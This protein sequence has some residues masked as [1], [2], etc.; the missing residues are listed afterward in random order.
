MPLRPKQQ[1]FVD[2]YLKDLNATQAAIRAGYSK[3][4]AMQIGEQ[5]LRKL[6]IKAA[7]DE[8]IRER[9]ERVK[10]TQ[11]EV[12]RELKRI[13]L[14]DPR[15]V[16]EWGPDGFKIKSS[17]ELS[18][19]AARIVAGISESPSQWGWRRQIKLADKLR[20]AELLGKHLGMFTDNVQVTGAGGGPVEI[21]EIRKAKK[22]ESN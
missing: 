12:L 22:R 13:A 8:A 1:R 10:V 17:D 3:K 18:E 2:E 15:S 6:E 5:N 16:M 19:D 4:S 14:Y 7:I 9:S 11:D 21:I 20:A